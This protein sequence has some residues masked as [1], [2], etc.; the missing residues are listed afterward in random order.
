MAPPRKS[1]GMRWKTI[2]SDRLNTSLT[3]QQGLEGL[4]DDRLDFIRCL[5][6]ILLKW[7]TWQYMIPAFTGL[8]LSD[9]SN[10]WSLLKPIE[11][12]N[13]WKVMYLKRNG[14]YRWAYLQDSI[15]GSIPPSH[16]SHI[17]VILST[18]GEWSSQLRLYS[19][20]VRPMLL[21]H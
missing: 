19:S 9:Q 12:A 8:V 14:A 20:S 13:M 7:E 2:S 18:V 16:Q 3:W 10:W 5:H 21:V 4:V 11:R 6:S 15:D 17:W 1:Q